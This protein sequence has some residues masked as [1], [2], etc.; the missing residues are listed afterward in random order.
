MTSMK[1]LKDIFQI[2]FFSQVLVTQIISKLMMRQKHGSI[3]NM[4]SVAGLDNFAGYTSYGCSK[5]AMMMFTKTIAREL[6]P[7]NI[8]VNSIAP[9]L[10]NTGMAGQMEEKAWREMVERTDMKRLG[11]PDE[12]VRMMLFLASDEA[13]FITG[14]IYRV[15]GGM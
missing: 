13:S 4:G 8:R 5:A 10:T 9:G 14:Q 3:I 2:N 15:D 6:A 7:Y 12:I 1:Q 11:N